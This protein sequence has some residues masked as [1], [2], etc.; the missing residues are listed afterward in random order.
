MNNTPDN[1]QIPPELIEQWEQ[2]ALSR[3][4]TSPVH[5]IEMELRDIRKAF[6]EG[7]QFQNSKTEADRLDPRNR[8]TY[9]WLN[10]AASGYDWE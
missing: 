1:K 3:W 9:D 4:P 8:N 7:C 10:S 2:E 6:V 5:F